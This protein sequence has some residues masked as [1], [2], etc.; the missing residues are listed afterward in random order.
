MPY[1]LDLVL[2]VA[3]VELHQPVDAKATAR[4]T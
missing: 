1:L 2:V 4:H 3:V